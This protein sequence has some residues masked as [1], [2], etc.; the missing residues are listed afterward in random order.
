MT[1]RPPDLPDDPRG[2]LGDDLWDRLG[3]AQ[4]PSVPAGFDARFRA[5][6]RDDSPWLRRHWVPISAGVGGFAAVAAALIMFL[7]PPALVDAPTPA[8][9]L[10]LVAELELVEN[11]ALLED[12]DLLL[13]WDGTTP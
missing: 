10:A 3:D 7:L 4:V 5:E 13:A 9:D 6:L 8:D 1:H 11:L 2:I 12:L